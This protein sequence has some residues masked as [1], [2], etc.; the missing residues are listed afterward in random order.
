MSSFDYQNSTITKYRTGTSDDPFIDIIET[1]KVINGQI[2]LNEI[3]ILLNKVRIN[4]M[5]E[6]P[7]TYTDTL[8]EKEY[9]VD[10]SE[11]IVSFHPS[12]E[13]LTLD[14]NYKGRGNHYVSAARI[15][16]KEHDG[17]VLETLGDILEVGKDAIGNI[18]ELSELMNNAKTAIVDANTATQEAHDG[19]TKANE[20]ATGANSQGKYAKDQGDYAKTQGDA[21]KKSAS[22]T[23]IA[24][25]N[26][27]QATDK[28]NLA[29]T[30]ANTAHDLAID[31]AAN[32]NQKANYAQEQGDY[33]KTSTDELVEIGTS[34]ANKGIY[35]NSITYKPLN[36]VVYS[37]GVY[38]NTQ[39]CKGILPT[40]SNYWQL[41]MQTATSVTWDSVVGKPDVDGHINNTSNPHKVTAAQVGAYSKAES[42]GKYATSTNL[43]AHT[44]DTNIHLQTGERTKWNGKQDALGFTPE[45]ISKKGKA[46]GYASLDSSGYVPSSQ[47]SLPSN[48][49]TTTGAQ[50]KV[51]ALSGAGNTKTV[52]QVDDA[53]TAHLADTTK[54]ITAAERTS[55][56]NA[57]TDIGV[58]GNLNTSAK[59]NL[60][61]A[62]NELFTSVA[63][64]KNSIASAISGKGIS[65]SGSD[66]FSALAA[67]IG[68]INTGIASVQGVVTGN[69][70]KNLIIPTSFPVKVAILWKGTSN[71]SGTTNGVVFG[72]LI[73]GFNTGT[74]FWG[75]GGTTGTDTLYNQTNSYYPG[76][77]CCL[78]NKFPGDWNYIL[79]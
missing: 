75:T 60:V 61:A 34:L 9:R 48:L 30:T 13:G 73:D 68:Q 29:T 57:V 41:L 36:I 52:K 44:N 5:F 1:K 25:G 4:Y 21:A 78:A 50:A 42:D 66:E 37:S 70:D 77:V 51:D 3:P 32:A 69:A 45:D 55:W 72:K 64:G 67:K 43:T 54:H 28:A 33:A 40:N 11:G 31:A 26:A 6:V 27:N 65:A 20:A 16:T 49:E 53:V 24:T 71:I 14:L 38:Q 74:L 2:Q 18:Q 19:A 59:S 8:K 47:L 76:S 7:S 79:I 39:E 15:W 17:E 10:Y 62:I 22:D 58:K 46:N 12:A 56:N 63:N 35:D 23:V